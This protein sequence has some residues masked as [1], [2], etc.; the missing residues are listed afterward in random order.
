MAMEIM[1]RLFALL[2]AS[3]FTL[4]FLM[5]FEF[6]NKW[7]V[8]L[9][10]LIPL[11]IVGLLFPIAVFSVMI[12]AASPFIIFLDIKRIKWQKACIFVLAFFIIGVLF[13]K[14]LIPILPL[15]SY[16][17]LVFI[18]VGIAKGQS[19]RV[20]GNLNSTIDTLDETI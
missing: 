6:E 11:I 5:L 17:A 19:K 14:V 4:I 3:V 10:F 7:K 1:G 13:T 2:G 8:Y 9:S 16:P 18:Y 20:N 15:Y 12:L